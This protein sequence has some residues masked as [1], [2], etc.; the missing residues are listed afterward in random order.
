[1][2]GRIAVDLARA[3]LKDPG[4][5]ALGEAEAIDRAHDGGLGR[6][7]RV[8]LVVRR[9]SGAGEIVDLIHLE[10][11]RIDYI[12]PDKLEARVLQQVRNIL[13]SAGEQVVDDGDIMTVRDETVTEM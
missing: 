3:G 11:K 5:H 7:D 4:L 9:R 10:L 6:L 13:L 1:M 8:E 12:V 2:H